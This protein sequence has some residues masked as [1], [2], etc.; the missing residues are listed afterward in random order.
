[1]RSTRFWNL[2][3][4]GNLTDRLKIGTGV[5]AKLISFVIWISIYRIF[6]CNTMKLFI[7]WSILIWIGGFRWRGI[8]KITGGLGRNMWRISSRRIK[9]RK[10]ERFA[11]NLIFNFMWRWL[12]LATFFLSS[13][14]LTGH[15]QDDK[16]ML[17]TWMKLDQAF[18]LHKNFNH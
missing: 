12:I 8:C 5:S 10:F 7:Q 13:A 6:L 3:Y 4:D 9:S 11:K 17:E 1:M 2:V 15:K 14:M 18:T 16:S